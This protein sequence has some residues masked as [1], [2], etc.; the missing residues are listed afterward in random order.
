MPALIGMSNAA[1]KRQPSNEITPNFALV[2]GK[3]P[4]FM[5]VGNNYWHERNLL[6]LQNLNPPLRVNPYGIAPHFS[7]TAGSSWAFTANPLY[8]YSEFTYVAVFWCGNIDTTIRFLFAGR[9]NFNTIDNT[10]EAGLASNSDGLQYYANGDYYDLNVSLIALEGKLHVVTVGMP[11]S[12]NARI[13]VNGNMNTSFPRQSIEKNFLVIGRSGSSTFLQ[14][15][16]FAFYDQYLMPD[17]LMLEVNKNPWILCSPKPSR[18]Y[19]IPTAP[20]LTI[21]TLSAPGVTDITATAARP[22]VTLTY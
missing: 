22:Q 14:P 13:C 1:W 18:F 4:E 15:L 10:P 3:A 2:D 9:A 17:A 7:L 12:G 19:L 20:V 6:R 16:M 11:S 8:S 21:P 5:T